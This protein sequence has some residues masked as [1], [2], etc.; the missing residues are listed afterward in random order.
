MK[1]ANSHL[2]RN[3]KNSSASDV[4]VVDDGVATPTS[5]DG[6][7]GATPLGWGTHMR[8]R[9]AN[10]TK[11]KLIS[12]FVAQSLE[13]EILPGTTSFANFAQKKRGVA[14]SR[15]FY[16]LHRDSYLVKKKYSNIIYDRVPQTEW[17]RFP[18]PGGFIGWRAAIIRQLLIG[19]WP[20]HSQSEVACFFFSLA[21]QKIG[22]VLITDKAIILEQKN[23]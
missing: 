11:K 3:N 9:T 17:V 5:I 16:N 19:C 21:T 12:H 23:S 10:E 6:R 14:Y 15:F 1:R 8:G 20:S 22:F 4:V 18:N 13:H 7:R 2:A